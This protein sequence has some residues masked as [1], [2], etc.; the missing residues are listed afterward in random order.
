MDFNLICSR[1]QALLIRNERVLLPGVGEFVVESQSAAFL[2]DGKTIA[3]PSKKLVF[4]PSDICMEEDELFVELSGK[5]REVLSKNENFEIPGFGVFSRKGDEEVVFT[6]NEEFDFAPDNFS[7]EAISLEEVQR[8]EP[9]VEEIVE[10]EEVK[11]EEKVVPV[12]DTVEEVVKKEVT[13]KVSDV[14]HKKDCRRKW[15]MGVVLALVFVAVLVLFAVLFKE[16]LMQ[17]LQNIL[18]TDEELEIMKKWA[19]Q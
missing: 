14:E 12:I 16:D 17:M 10:E 9:V 13:D 6:L 11:A 19:A 8:E 15:M 7:L 4:L 1:I 18:Y 5:I 3:P 2:Q